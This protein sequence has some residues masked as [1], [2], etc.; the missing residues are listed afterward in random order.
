MK[1]YSAQELYDI[2]KDTDECVFIEAKGEDD[3]AE[4][5][6]ESVC[7]FSNE[8]G[9]GG[10]YFL[11]LEK[12]KLQ[13]ITGFLLRE[14]LTQIKSSSIFQLNVQVCLIFRFVQELMLRK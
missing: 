2:L 3:T 8:P 9:L 10:G 12:I 7:S 13:M 4:S 6:M 11:E 1:N 5:L 14:L